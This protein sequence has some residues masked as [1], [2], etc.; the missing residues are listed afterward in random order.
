MGTEYIDIK[1][2]DAHEK[3]LLKKIDEAFK[4]Y[5]LSEIYAKDVNDDYC[6]KKLAQLRLEFAKHGL[7]QAIEEALKHG[8]NIQDSKIYRQI[9]KD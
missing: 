2:Q 4:T 5:K 8:I 7:V 9:L 3:A 1:S 6:K